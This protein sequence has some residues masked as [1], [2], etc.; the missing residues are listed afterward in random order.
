[1]P[2]DAEAAEG[3]RRQ[4]LAF[5]TPRVGEPAL[6]EDLAQETLV[7][8]LRGLPGFRGDAPLSAWAR[9]IALNVWRDHLRQRTTERSQAAPDAEPTPSSFD[10]PDRR[11]T[12][13][14]VLEAIA[15]L[16]LESRRVLLL[17]EFGEM[18]LTETAA[19]L[20]CS[21]GAARVRLHRARRRLAQVCG[22]ECVRELTP[23]G[24]LLCTPK[25][26]S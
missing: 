26:T 12:H 18:S 25:P 7:R 17:H 11:A 8:V 19:A 4:I 3:L 6:A 20:G 23:E 5:L 22:D 2:L 15:E 14:C 9:R 21:E 16:P 24:S 13:D 10:R 1:M